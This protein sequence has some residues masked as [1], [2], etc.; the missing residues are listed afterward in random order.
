MRMLDFPRNPLEKPGYNLVFQDD[1]DANELD[2]TKWLPFY[3]PQWSSRSNAAANYRF[4]DSQILLSITEDQKPWCPEFNGDVK[5]SNL[6]TGTFSGPLGSDLGQHRF[7]RDCLVREEQLEERLFV[8]Q[9]GYFEIRARGLG[10]PR[11]VCAFWMIGFED[12]S[13][14]S[15]EI[16]P[17]ELKGWNVKE[18]SCTLGFGIHPFGDPSI[19][20]EF[21]ER[22]FEMDPT[23]YHVY[24]VDW[25]PE[26]IDFYIDNVRVHRSQ[27]SPSYSMQ[28][29]LNIY[30]IPPQES[31]SDEPA[32]YPS[33]FAIDYIR[34]YRRQENGIRQ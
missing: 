15:A 5:V 14:R 23:L 33:E 8:P 21:I 29:M 25:T 34:C 17:F 24:A 2:R 12:T 1:F 6:Q 30:E 32:E 3:L 31:G 26:G 28:L 27:Q 18:G 16:C 4:E 9:Y 13:E 20:E 22:E 11:N 10:T 19:E 7:S